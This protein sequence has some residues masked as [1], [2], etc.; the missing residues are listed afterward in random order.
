MRYRLRTL[1]IVL[2]LGPPVVAVAWWQYAN[3]RARSH[4][5]TVRTIDPADFRPDLA[6]PNEGDPTGRQP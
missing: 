5:S 4:V 6:W 1:L 3:W 2:A